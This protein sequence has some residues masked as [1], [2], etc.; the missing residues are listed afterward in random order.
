[1]N[2]TT[3]DEPSAHLSEA[4]SISVDV[5]ILMVRMFSD[6]NTSTQNSFG[7]DIHSS[8]RPDASFA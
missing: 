8:I 4:F 5:L 6:I 2:V 1:V 7:D 3:F